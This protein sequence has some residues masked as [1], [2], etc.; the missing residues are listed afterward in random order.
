MARLFPGSTR[1][2]QLRNYHYD[3]RREG[4]HFLRDT[5]EQQTGQTTVPTFADDENVGF[6][7]LN[8]INDLFCGI[9]PRGS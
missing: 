3:A 2:I 5:T 9:T 7:A 1:A 4:R 8:R 6:L